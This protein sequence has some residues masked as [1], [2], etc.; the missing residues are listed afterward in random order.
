MTNFPV[1]TTILGS[2][3]H[4]NLMFNEVVEL[5]LD[6]YIEDERVDLMLTMKGLQKVEYS[7]QLLA[8]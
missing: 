7:H 5:W 6:G 8:V 2:L 1:D 4:C 3:V